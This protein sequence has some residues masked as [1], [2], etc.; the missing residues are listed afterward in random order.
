[1][2]TINLD[3]YHKFIFS[4]GKGKICPFCQGTGMDW[5]YRVCLNCG[6]KGYVMEKG[7]VV[8]SNSLSDM[9]TKKGILNYPDLNFLSTFSK[10]T[11]IPQ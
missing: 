2:T 5:K 9:N 4:P 7:N 10:I 8:V 1:M 3:A 11:L 6:G